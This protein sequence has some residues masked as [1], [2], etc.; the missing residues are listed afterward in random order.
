[1]EDQR[2]NRIFKA[3]AYGYGHWMV[4]NGEIDPTERIHTFQDV[5]IIAMILGAGPS[6][7]HQTMNKAGQPTNWSLAISILTQILL[8]F[9]FV[10]KLQKYQC[11]DY[12]LLTFVETPHRWVHHG[13]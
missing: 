10:V 7:M 13:L 5:I 2:G 1:L 11:L 6:A 9:L 8:V 4:S 12:S 3:L